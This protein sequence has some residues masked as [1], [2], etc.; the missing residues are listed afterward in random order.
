MLWTQPYIVIAMI[1]M[2]FGFV[3]TSLII[4][5][6]SRS[7]YFKS[8][9]LI[10]L[11]VNTLAFSAFLIEYV[12]F[13]S[14]HF[15]IDGALQ[16]ILIH[17]PDPNALIQQLLAISIILTILTGILYLMVRSTERNTIGNLFYSNTTP[18]AILNDAELFDSNLAFDEI[19]K[20]TSLSHLHNQEKV[21]IQGKTYLIKRYR[22]QSLFTRNGIL[23]LVLQDVSD[24]EVALRRLD[25]LDKR[26]SM[27]SLL[28]KNKLD[29]LEKLIALKSKNQIAIELH[30]EI[31]H[32]L[33]LSISLLERMKDPDLRKS[34]PEGSIERMLEEGKLITQSLTQES[35]SPI[36]GNYLQE[37]LE[38]YILYLKWVG[39]RVD[40]DFPEQPL[41]LTQNGIMSL[42]AICKEAFSNTVKYGRAD[43]VKVFI[44]I[45]KRNL[46]ELLELRIEDNGL[47]CHRIIE[48]NGLKAIRA[49]VERNGGSF[50]YDGNRGFAMVCVFPLQQISEVTL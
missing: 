13:V 11:I 48:G 17:L 16:G 27:V 31:G 7:A 23:T 28:L 4:N 8:L 21:T 12:H 43:V 42:Y 1:E 15:E 39:I 34:I 35:R 22:S 19:I 26:L 6:R 30:D 32:N 29:L 44:S 20:G 37:M 46:D 24:Q 18:I 36:L 41:R 10:Q 9:Y 2:G 14:D 38:S 3:I 5:E 40:L 47:G 33:T 50:I 25:Q 45:R 49:R